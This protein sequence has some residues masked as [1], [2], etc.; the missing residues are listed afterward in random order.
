MRA[1]YPALFD[2]LL[3]SELRLAELGVVEP[4]AL[5]RAVDRFMSD[6]GEFERVALFHTLK[7]ELWLRARPC[8]ATPSA[9]A[10]A[11]TGMNART[12]RALS[13]ATGGVT[14]SR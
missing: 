6:G 14:A 12:D 4:A 13:V 8:T 9:R 2:A 10:A 1:H 5:R 3:G 11:R 7:T